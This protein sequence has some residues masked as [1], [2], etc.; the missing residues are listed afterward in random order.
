MTTTSETRSRSPTR[1]FLTLYNPP[2]GA[3]TLAPGTGARVGRVAEPGVGEVNAAVNSA[4]TAQVTWGGRSH[5]ER[6]E[7]H[8]RSAGAVDASA[9]APGWLLSR[10]Q[11]IPL[12]GPNARLKSKRAAPGS[13]RPHPSTW[14]PN[15]S[16]MKTERSRNFSAG[17]SA[18][19]GP[20]DRGTGP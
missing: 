5:E 8:R 7:L 16:W 19:S 12:N 10:E 1:P 3:P 13:M 20:S 18:S 15:R 11:G 14:N 17:R 4:T 9:D 6:S 2:R